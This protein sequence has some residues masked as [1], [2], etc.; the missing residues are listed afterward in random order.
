MYQIE[1]TSSYNEASKV[2]ILYCKAFLKLFTVK[3]FILYKEIQL[4]TELYAHVVP[5][6]VSV[7]YDDS[8]DPLKEKKIFV[9][10][11]RKCTYLTTKEIRQVTRTCIKINELYHLNGYDLKMTF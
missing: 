7:K 9:I 3:V 6:L 2:S 5:S 8:Y 10:I 1:L 4:V 11:L